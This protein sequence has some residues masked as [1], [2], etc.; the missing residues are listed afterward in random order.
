MYSGKVMNLVLYFGSFFFFWEGFISATTNSKCA[1]CVCLAPDL[2]LVVS[3]GSFE[4]FNTGKDW[5]KIL[6]MVKVKSGTRC[7]NN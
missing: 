1:V 6:G 2:A 4:S 3:R 7:E 5:Q